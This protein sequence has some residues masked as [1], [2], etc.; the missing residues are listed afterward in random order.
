MTSKIGINWHLRFREEIK[1]LK[2]ELELTQIWLDRAEKQLEKYENN[3][4][5]AAGNGKNNNVVRL[6][7][8]VHPTR[9]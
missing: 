7:R 1:Y 3:N 5:G 9:D 4:T 8:R 2:E 6:S